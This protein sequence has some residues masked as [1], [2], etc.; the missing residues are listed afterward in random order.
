MADT[1]EPFCGTKAIQPRHFSGV[2]LRQNL[3]GRFYNDHDCVA[4]IFLKYNFRL[5]LYNK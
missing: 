2:I 1:G 4:G 5:Y 3:A